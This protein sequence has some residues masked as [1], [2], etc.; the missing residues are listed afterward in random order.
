MLSE[1][2]AGII[3]LVDRLTS[4]VRVAGK[5]LGERLSEA[6]GSVSIAASDV[7]SFSGV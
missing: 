5:G 6:A 4:P 3:V 1:E 7:N 2:A